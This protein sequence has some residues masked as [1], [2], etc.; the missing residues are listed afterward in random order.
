M[1]WKLYLGKPVFSL[2]R[3]L[4]VEGDDLL[5]KFIGNVEDITGGPVAKTLHFSA[6]GLGSIPRQGPQICSLIR[7][8]D[9]ACHS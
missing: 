7:E 6:G 3:G 1:V 8:L 2:K 9:S 4:L 5:L